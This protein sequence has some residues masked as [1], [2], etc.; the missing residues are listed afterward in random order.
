MD[1]VPTEYSA[2]VEVYEYDPVADAWT[3]K[4]R[5]PRPKYAPVCQECS[6]LAYMIGGT[7]GTYGN[8][9]KR[10]MDAY[11]PAAGTWSRCADVTC[12]VREILSAHCS[13]G[14][15]I[16][17]FG[18]YIRGNQGILQLPRVL[19][20]DPATDVWT[21]KADMP[22]VQSGGKCFVIGA[23]VY[24]AF[25]MDPRLCSYWE[26]PAPFMLKYDPASDAWSWC[27]DHPAAG[28]LVEANGRIYIVGGL[29]PATYTYLDFLYEY[30]PAGDAWTAK[31]SKPLVNWAEVLVTN[32]GRIYAFCDK[33]LPVEEYDPSSDTWAVKSDVPVALGGVEHYWN[34]YG[35]PLSR[36][37]ALNSMIYLFSIRSELAEYDPAADAWAMKTLV[38]R[39]SW[40]G[41]AGYVVSGGKIYVIGGYSDT[42]PYK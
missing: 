29:D 36:G 25:V 30:D 38:P 23:Q 11:D 2:S 28:P 5:M 24:V 9:D 7:A 3:K 42:G 33:D 4:A 27:A 6:G 40:S 39:P 13:I 35:V 12:S 41:T 34:G 18:S 20:Y 17:V 10:Y 14:G 15:R 31:S 1:P 32:G 8:R 22:D 21:N 16:Y 37:I 26:Y 19:E